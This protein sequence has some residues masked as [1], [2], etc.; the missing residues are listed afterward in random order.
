MKVLKSSEEFVVKKQSALVRL[1]VVSFVALHTAQS[2]H[3]DTYNFYFDKKKKGGRV[4]LQPHSE[5][6]TELEDASPAPTEQRYQGP[7]A[8]NAPIVIHNNVGTPQAAPAA[9]VEPP[10]FP[11]QTGSDH[12]V[13]PSPLD[14]NTR[15]PQWKFGFG[16][17]ALVDE[18]ALRKSY[19]RNWDIDDFNSSVS[20]S[21]GSVGG[22]FSL[23]YRFKPALGLSAFLGGVKGVMGTQTDVVMGLDLE[24]VPLRLDVGSFDLLEVAGLFGV[25]GRVGGSSKGT[26][27][28]G[29]RVNVNLGPNFSLTTAIRA[30]ANL[31]MGEL[32]VAVSL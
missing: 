11:S 27:H 32:G 9:P 16:A 29:A 10:A 23:G 31:A 7:R 19:L 21:A 22:I 17:M 12:A 14:P 8:G 3:A 28:I 30:N 26:A 20:S 4:E 24:W 25:L 5:E 1:F 15:R 13:V 18:S 2:V 6:E